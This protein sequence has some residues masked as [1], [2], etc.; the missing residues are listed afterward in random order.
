ME[1][2]I[3]SKLNQSINCLS[4]CDDSTVYSGA[5]NSVVEWNLN[6][7]SV[8]AKWTAG[9]EKISAILLIPESSKLLTASKSIKLWDI[10][11][12]EVLKT[13]TG[14]S[15]E[16][17]LMHYVHPR[18]TSADSYFVSASKGDRI[19][20]CWNLN[21]DQD[22]KNAVANLLMEDI[23]QN[24]SIHVSQDGCTNVAAVVRSGVVHI[25]QHTLNG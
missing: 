7:K 15:G 23:A 13:F 22:G 6:K 3:N 18:E 12:Q 21:P 17:C 11:S 1:Y 16:V 2:T 24:L 25:Y 8:G 5:N 20:S 4:A 10:S 19:L 9:N 14:H